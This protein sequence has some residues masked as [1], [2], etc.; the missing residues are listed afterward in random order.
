[1]TGFKFVDGRKWKWLEGVFLILQEF[2]SEMTDD[3]IWKRNEGE[4]LSFIKF[5]AF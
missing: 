1:M 4:P 2:Q 3:V 5:L